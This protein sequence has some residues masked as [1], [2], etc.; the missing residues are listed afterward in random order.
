MSIRSF[1]FV[2][3]LYTYLIQIVLIYFLALH[4]EKFGSDV[5]TK[6]YLV[7]ILISINRFYQQNNGILEQ[8]PLFEMLQDILTFIESHLSEDLSLNR[9][10][11]H[12]FRQIVS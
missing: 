8:Y 1:T 4:S 7:E 3:K 11:N 5:L 9:I 10:S 2:F 12:F 6:S